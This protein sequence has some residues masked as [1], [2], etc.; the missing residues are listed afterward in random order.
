MCDPPTRR[1]EE[2]KPQYKRFSWEQSF[3]EL[4]NTTTDDRCLA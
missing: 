4:I 3:C 2:V 1:P